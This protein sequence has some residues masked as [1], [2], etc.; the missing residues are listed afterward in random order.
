MMIT[1]LKIAA[2]DDEDEDEVD[3]SGDVTTVAASL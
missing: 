3:G 2:K 1:I